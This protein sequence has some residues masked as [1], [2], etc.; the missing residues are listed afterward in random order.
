MP[1]SATSADDMGHIK[2]M[3]NRADPSVVLET[4]DANA[5]WLPTLVNMGL[6]ATA[7]LPARWMVKRVNDPDMIRA[8]L[9][10]E[11][12]DDDTQS[13]IS[14]ALA[15]GDPVVP[16]VRR[17]AWRLLIRGKQRS[18][19]TQ[20]YRSWEWDERQL[21]ASGAEPDTTTCHLVAKLLRPR[22]V[23]SHPLPWHLLGDTREGEQERLLDLVRVAFDPVLDSPPLDL[24]TVWP[25]SSRANTALFRVLDRA[26]TDA[27]DEIAHDVGDV[28]YLSS[29]TIPMVG[30]LSGQ[31]FGWRSGFRPIAKVLVDLTS[32][33]VAHDVALARQLV[34]PW[35]ERGYVLCSRL[36]LFVGSQEWMPSEDAAAMVIGLHEN[37]FWAD[38]AEPELML[39]LTKRWH[40]VDPREAN[41]IEARLRTG[42]SRDLY[43]ED[44]VADDVAWEAFRAYTVYRR[45]SHLQLSGIA[46]SNASGSIVRELAG[47]NPNWTPGIRERSDDWRRLAPFSGPQGD[48]RLLADVPDDRVVDEAK[49]L[50]RERPGEQSHLWR[51]FCREDPHRAL[52]GLRYKGEN[53]QWD[54]AALQGFFWEAGDVG[55]ADLQGACA[56]LA[57]GI[58]EEFLRKLSDTMASWLSSQLAVL[59]QYDGGKG[60][61]EL[62]NRLA[63]IVYVEPKESATELDLDSGL[64]RKA[65]ND[66]GG[67]L[68][69]ALIRYAAREG[70]ASPGGFAKAFKARGKQVVVSPTQSGLFGRMMV[71]QH[72]AYLY[73]VD[74]P[75]VTEDIVPLLNWENDEAAAL[76]WSYAAHGRIGPPRLF[77]I[78]K[79]GMLEGAKR[80]EITGDALNSLVGKVIQVY[81]W[82]MLERNLEYQLTA[83]EVKAF[84]R[85]APSEG[86]VHAA[87]LLW[88]IISDVDADNEEGRAAQWHTVVGPLF[89]A[90]WPMDLR[91]RSPDVSRRLVYMGLEC[92]DALPDV[93]DAVV[94]VLVPYTLPSVCHW[95]E[96]GDGRSRRPQEHARSLVRMADA[97]IQPDAVPGD[98]GVFLQEC[99]RMDPEIEEDSSYIR[100]RSIRRPSA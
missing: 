8:C 43:L 61:L 27:L 95:L 56:R 73:N 85:N 26:F 66:P 69:D 92:D 96:T 29:G 30:K 24:L 78:L 1:T 74:A 37:V 41:A 99:L 98:L 90:I 68:A 16:L 63:A 9:D 21:L 44:T 80:T 12:I 50:E 35:A 58:P 71:V 52:E 31:E 67:R 100:L 94:D 4:V 81:Y 48:A 55:D 97:V 28:E 42:P 79:R 57:A 84:L 25:D 47:E 64:L 13:A 46:L 19:Y 3:L 75:W 7:S 59:L 39:L 15:S 65:L 83:A 32:R 82:L 14:R 88:G 18:R 23:V 20:L 6:F 33:I 36:A 54:T 22:A 89:Q 60:F 51:V 5:A 62:W 72:L 53:G 34:R 70:A 17:Q 45:L 49:R 93:V 91:C 40:G 86:R 2:R 87:W 77:N 10:L 11:S 38:S 76:W